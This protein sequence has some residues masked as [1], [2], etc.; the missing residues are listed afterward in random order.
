MGKLGDFM[1]EFS[2]SSLIWLQ[3]QIGALSFC[4][5][6]NCILCMKSSYLIWKYCAGINDLHSWYMGERSLNSLPPKVYSP[7]SICEV[8][9]EHVTQRSKNWQVTR[10]DKNCLALCL[11]ARWSPITTRLLL[12]PLPLYADSYCSYSQ[13]ISCILLL[14]VC[15]ELAL[16]SDNWLK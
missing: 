14:F 7:Y 12:H 5:W 4:F 6:Q 3:P 16:N 9:S 13:A 2:L 15:L 1:M 8:Y 10:T 11:T